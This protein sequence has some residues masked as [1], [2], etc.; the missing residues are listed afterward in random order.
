MNDL[1]PSVL[2]GRYNAVFT[3]SA[4]VG[5]VIGPAIA[6]V[7]LGHRYGTGLFVGLFAACL[8]GALLAR[9]SRRLV[10]SGPTE[11]LRR[12]GEHSLYALAFFLD[13]LLNRTAAGSCLLVESSA[14]NDARQKSP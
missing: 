1:A 3:L 13:P 8:T 12:D 2:R 4:Q 9:L 10:P 11:S 6:G 14:G 5:P 7:T